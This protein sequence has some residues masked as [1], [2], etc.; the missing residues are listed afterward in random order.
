[1][2]GQAPEDPLD[3]EE[4]LQE[5]LESLPYLCRFKSDTMS[6]YLCQAFDQAL[7][8]YSALGQGTTPSSAIEMEVRSLHFV[9]LTLEPPGF[10][11][12]DVG[13]GITASRP[14]H[15]IVAHIADVDVAYRGHKI[16]CDHSKAALQV[17]EGQITWFVYMVGAIIKGRLT[18]GSTDTQ[19]VMD[20][21]LSARVLK[22][23][24]VVDTP[25]LMQV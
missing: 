7:A 5:Q 22:L 18:T 24:L 9:T 12:S 1:V 16:R 19:E 2:Q 17:L 11:M 14:D 8:R 20:G 15:S 6:Q 21:D 13:H 25:V 3:N 4:Q 10:W 23:L